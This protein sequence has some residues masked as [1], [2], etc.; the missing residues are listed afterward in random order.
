MH[1]QRGLKVPD[2]TSMMTSLPFILQ[3]RCACETIFDM[4]L[5][6]YIA[7]LKAYYNQSEE[8]GKKHGTK[9]PSLDG[10]DQALQWAEHALATFREAECQCKGGDLDSADASVDQAL[11]ALQERY[12]FNSHLHI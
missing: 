3:L 1:L 5:S 8:R 9:Q 11:L 2:F 12:E 7:G 4:I 10:W 6:A